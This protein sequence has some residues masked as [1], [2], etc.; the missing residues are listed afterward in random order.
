MTFSRCAL[1]SGNKSSRQA[2]RELIR[3][4]LED[5]IKRQ[6]ET[7]SFDENTSTTRT[8]KFVPATNE[9]DCGKHCS[10]DTTQVLIC[11]DE[12]VRQHFARALGKSE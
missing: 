7:Q 9:V 10:I 11:L 1:Q 4:A 2:K 3:A 12:L 5:G 6:R 8:C